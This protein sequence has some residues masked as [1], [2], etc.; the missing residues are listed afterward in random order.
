M[1]EATTPATGKEQQRPSFWGRGAYELFLEKEGI[2]VHTGVAV[3]DLRTADLAK[4]PRLDA[5][6]AYIRLAGAEDTDNAYLIELDP[7]R[8][9]AP[10]KHLFEEYFFVLNGRGTCEVWNDGEEPASFEWQEG[11]LFSVPLNTTH[12]LHN[13]SGSLSARLLAVTTMPI[14]MN[15]LHNTDFMFNCPYVFSDRYDGRKEYFDG[16]GTLYTGRV[17]ETN[18][19]ADVRRFQLKDWLE[20]G[21]GG[22]NIRFEFA[23]NTM[24]SHVSEFPVGTYK[25]CHRHGPGYHVILL[26]GS[27]YS[28]M[29]RE[30]GDEWTEVNWKTGTLFVPPGRW[31]HQHFNTGSDPARYLA[32]RWGGNKWKLAEYL[33]NQGVDK[34]VTEGGNQI[35]YEDQDPQIH[36]TYLE[37]CAQNGVKVRMDEFPVRV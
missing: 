1:S 16:A 19:V 32:I 29:W 34:D 15:L 17:W 5:R 10:E 2:P 35:E 11:S 4:W 20:R 36:R 14:M 12:R 30:N 28:Y 31:W 9:S 25:K 24:V 13:G 23:N 37:R 18:F 26:N 22:K 27:G 7:G 8:S 3:A 33:D 21:A 6:G